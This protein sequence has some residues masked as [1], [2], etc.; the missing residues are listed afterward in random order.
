MLFK[1]YLLVI[2]LTFFS[3][4]VATHGDEVKNSGSI[5]QKSPPIDMLSELEEQKTNKPPAEKLEKHIFKAAYYSARKGVTLRKKN[6]IDL[7]A[8]DI[9]FINHLHRLMNVHITRSQIYAIELGRNNQ[10]LCMRLNK[11]REKYWRDLVEEVRLKKL[12]NC[13][14]KAASY[15]V[16]KAVFLH[17]MHVSQLHEFTMR[18]VNRCHTSMNKALRKAEFY[19]SKTDK[20]LPWV[21][22]RFNSVRKELLKSHQ[23]VSKIF[24]K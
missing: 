18:R 23:E 6:S 16:R 15:S 20:N 2:Y 19:G 22:D 24:C 17:G 21:I 3:P 8:A 11:A 7:D 9:N 4:L 13:I 1:F 14:K 10:W 5:L 12:E